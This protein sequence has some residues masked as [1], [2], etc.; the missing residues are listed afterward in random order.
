MEIASIELEYALYISIS[1]LLIILIYYFSLKELYRFDTFSAVARLT[2]NNIEY[3][4]KPLYLVL[5][6]ITIVSFIILIIILKFN[7]NIIL[8]F[9]IGVFTTLFIPLF[10][11]RTMYCYLLRTIY[12]S[13]NYPKA[14]LTPIFLTLSYI[15]I[16]P[17]VIFLLCFYLFKQEKANSLEY[18]LYGSLFVSFLFIIGSALFCCFLAK[19]IKKNISFKLNIEF[20]K[21]LIYSS[22]GVLLE[23]F[24][25]FTV[26]LACATI[27]G[28]FVPT[29]NIINLS[30]IENIDITTFFPIGIVIIM[31]VFYVIYVLLFSI[32]RKVYHN[33]IIHFYL[34]CLPLFLLASILFILLNYISIKIF[35]P[36]LCGALFNFLLYIYYKFYFK[37]KNIDFFYIITLFSFFIGIALY[38]SGLYGFIIFGTVFAL[39][40]LVF[41][42][43]YFLITIDECLNSGSYLL[44][45]DNLYRF[46]TK[47]ERYNTLTILRLLL[48]LQGLMANLSILFLIQSKYNLSLIIGN[49][50][51]IPILFLIL[52]LIFLLFNVDYNRVLKP[53]NVDHL[54]LQKHN[55]SLL[56]QKYVELVS[57]KIILIL[58]LILL[59]SAIIVF[60]TVFFMTLTAFV[61]Y[62]IITIIGFFFAIFSKKEIIY[63][64]TS[65][66]ISRV[67]LI[68]SFIMYQIIFTIGKTL[69]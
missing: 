30:N 54:D 32:G 63:I 65:N 5:I 3:F 31:A 8:S 58:F 36:I 12:G 6:F 56:F 40:N 38:F 69:N 15:L 57:K 14:Y 10:S 37:D 41:I 46:Y 24:S 21:K 18:F 27:L 16:A 23:F 59:I 62:F 29:R 25:S 50:L 51:F 68:L 64:V 4:S 61:I 39:F 11:Q 52:A 28:I 2:K 13:N 35:I 67:L 45:S 47:E 60:L 19:Y 66:N 7:I 17:S 33:D 42:M 44:P 34:I 55:A 9:T 20:T 43:K 1:I 53:K 48:L 49:M 26:I 22:Y